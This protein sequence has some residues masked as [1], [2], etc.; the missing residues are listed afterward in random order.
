[1]QPFFQ[2]AI[3]QSSPDVES[4]QVTMI[5]LQ[6]KA[7]PAL[8]FRT[9]AQYMTPTVLL[10]EQLQCA[11][12]DLSCFRNASYQ[13]IVVAQQKVDKMITSFQLPIS[14]RTMGT[15]D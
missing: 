6:K 2:A 1:M 13:S 8:L 10:A 4:V 11:A 3:I 12:R 14:F 15:G 5:A 9:Y 7:F